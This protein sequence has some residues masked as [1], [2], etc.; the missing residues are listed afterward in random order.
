MARG[1]GKTIE[2][3]V[4]HQTSPSPVHLQHS[5]YMLMFYAYGIFSKLTLNT[6]CLNLGASGLWMCIHHCVY[7]MLYVSLRMRH[8]ARVIAYTSLCIHHQTFCSSAH[9]NCKNKT[10][11]CYFVFHNIQI[12]IQCMFL[13]LLSQIG[14]SC[15]LYFIYIFSSGL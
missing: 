13:W 15:R 1:M 12:G 6:F 10:I 5:P 3:I 7:I 9:S 2:N 8:C 11:Y 4:V 14:Q